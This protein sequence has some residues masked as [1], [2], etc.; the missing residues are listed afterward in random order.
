VTAV[1][2]SEI[3]LEA[4]SVCVHGDSPGAVAIASAVRKA[5]S[6]N[7]VQLSAFAAPGTA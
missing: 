6:D 2:G 4:D 7:G 5:L 1:D 3:H